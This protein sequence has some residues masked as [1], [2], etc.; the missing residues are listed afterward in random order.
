[1]IEIPLGSIGEFYISDSVFEV[2]PNMV[3]V[4]T[5]LSALLRLMR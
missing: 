3:N 1:M 5:F 2:A 4:H